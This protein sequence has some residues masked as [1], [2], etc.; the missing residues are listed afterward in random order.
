M[1]TSVSVGEGVG[2]VVSVGVGVSVGTGVEVGGVISGTAVSVAV[3][4]GGVFWAIG[5]GVGEKSQAEARTT[6]SPQAAVAANVRTAR[7]PLNR[8][9]KWGI[10]HLS[11]QWALYYYKRRGAW[12]SCAAR[13]QGSGADG[14]PTTDD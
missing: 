13:D 7:G 14:R 6:S 8:V 4:G 1:G 11:S 5:V 9:T 2:V 10:T 3:A 12:K